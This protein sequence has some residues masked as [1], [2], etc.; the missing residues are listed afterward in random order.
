MKHRQLTR[1]LVALLALIMLMCGCHTDHSPLHT[2]QAAVRPTQTSDTTAASTSAA[3]ET[4]PT[5]STEP[6]ALGNEDYL[7]RWQ[8]GGRR[9]YLPDEQLQMVPFS[10]MEYQRPDTEVLYLDFDALIESSKSSSEAETLLEDYYRLY[11][12]YLSFYSMD[13][14]ANIRYSLNTQDSFYK[15]EYDFCEAETPNVEEKLELLYK[16]F[17]ASPSRDQLETLYFGEGFFETYDDYE[18]YTNEEYLRLSKEEA[19]L[20]SEYR[21]LTANP[22]VTYRGRTKA[23][24]CCLSNIN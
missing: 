21:D 16:S 24:E 23:L 6:P 5:S 2:T 4:A 10:Q 19:A 3:P 1:L 17:A 18:V 7:I 15:T 9:D 13:T 20:L 22:M 11:D 8:N 14:L 12:R